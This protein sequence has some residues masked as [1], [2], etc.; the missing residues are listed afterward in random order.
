MPNLRE[1]KIRLRGISKTR[2]ITRAMKMVATV[3]LRRAQAALAGARPYGARLEELAAD[4]LAGL[5]DFPAENPFFRPQKNKRALVVIVAT[6]RGLC[7]NMNANV[8][9]RALRFMEELAAQ[10]PAT[11][12]EMEIL[13]IGRKARD[14]FKARQAAGLASAEYC[15]RDF[16]PFS[17]VAAGPLGRNCGAFYRDGTFD[18]IDFFY[19]EPVSALQHQAAQTGLLP[20]DRAG[21][22]KDRAGKNSFFLREPGGAAM[23]TEVITAYLVSRIRKIFLQAEVAEHAA[24]MLMMD[25]ATKNAD[26][27]VAEMRLDMNKLRQLSITRELADITTGVE[28]IG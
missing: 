23:L 17:G 6:D 9:R 10:P 14:F 16:M 20:L 27:L 28:A 21:L 5:D 7:G 13:L 26:D 18:R 24:R 3:K 15:L 22:Q 2:Q 11:R 19:T 12:P 1:M 25:L 4:L 8:F